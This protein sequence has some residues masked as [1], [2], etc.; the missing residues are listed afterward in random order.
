[1]PYIEMSMSITPPSR[2]TAPPIGTA[3]SSSRSGRTTAA[4]SLCTDLGG[5]G[6]ARA[7]Q[8]SPRR[9]RKRKMKRSVV[10]TVSGFPDASLL[11]S[12]VK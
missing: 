7:A 4:K 3:P 12:L 2:P 1:M 9:M 11:D 8:A 6:D 10:F 5:G